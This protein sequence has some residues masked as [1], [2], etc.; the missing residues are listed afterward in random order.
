MPVNILGLWMLHQARQTSPLSSRGLK[1][2]GG[3]QFTSERKNKQDNFRQ[4][5]VKEAD[6]S[7][8]RVNNVLV[9]VAAMWFSRLRKA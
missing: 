2:G 3:E 4:L 1:Y 9:V 8:D 5:K 7:R 6:K